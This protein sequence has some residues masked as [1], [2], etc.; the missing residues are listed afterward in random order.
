MCRRKKDFSV[1]LRQSSIADGT[2]IGWFLA[3]ESDIPSP[4]ALIYPCLFI[5]IIN[6]ECNNNRIC[7]ENSSS[8]LRPWI[9]LNLFS[10]FFE[11]WKKRLSFWRISFP[12]F[13]ESDEK[14]EQIFK[15]IQDHKTLDEFCTDLLLLHSIFIINMYRSE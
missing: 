6:I 9:F 12:L 4:T 10:F 1:I 2:L 15:K 14:K 11:G 13:W 5:L 3:F 8:A 7:R